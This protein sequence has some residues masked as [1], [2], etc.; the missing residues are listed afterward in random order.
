MTR[1]APA[2]SVHPLWICPQCR[3]ELPAEPPTGQ[4]TRS[5]LQIS[6]REVHG[7]AS[8]EQYPGSCPGCELPYAFESDGRFA[9]PY[10]QLLA[11]TRLR[12]FLRW[13]DAQNN[14]YISYA[15]MRGSS[16]SI[17]GR[18]DAQQFADFIRSSVTEAPDAVLDLG[19]GPLARPAYLPT[20]PSFR[21]RG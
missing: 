21:A 19:C 15:L 18:Q 12:R 3:A 2:S 6:T 9:Y 4:V 5:P 16:C 1:T 7:S 8:L 17:D 13:S 14:G 20:C 11:K 10:R